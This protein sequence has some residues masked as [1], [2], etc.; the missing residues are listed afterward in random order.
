MASRSPR[1]PFRRSS[2]V[3]DDRALTHTLQLDAQ[4]RGRYSSRR[5]VHPPRALLVS[6][7]HRLDSFRVAADR[8]AHGTR[9]SDSPLTPRCD[10]RRQ[11]SSCGVGM[12]VL[13]PSRADTA[14]GAVDQ[15]TSRAARERLARLRGS[16]R[17]RRPLREKVLRSDRSTAAPFGA[18]PMGFAQV[19]TAAPIRGVLRR[20]VDAEMRHQP[21][22]AERGVSRSTTSTLPTVPVE[23]A[24]TSRAR[25]LMSV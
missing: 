16:L 1:T 20:L 7:R 2:T 5:R 15:P 19:V 6:S 23:P 21:A 10:C 3:Q 8:L 4:H 14:A 17:L 22:I 9:S 11:R 13:D 18:T 12:P 24:I 25:P